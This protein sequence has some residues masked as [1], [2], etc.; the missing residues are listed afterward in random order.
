MAALMLF[1]V[2]VII[3]KRLQYTLYYTVISRLSKLISCLG[4]RADAFGFAR[5]KCEL[6]IYGAAL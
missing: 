5:K 1:L 6:V 2:L 4:A 3:G